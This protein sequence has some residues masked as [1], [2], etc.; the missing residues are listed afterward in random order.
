MKTTITTFTQGTTTQTM[1]RAKNISTQL[2]ALLTHVSAATG[3]INWVTNTTWTTGTPQDLTVAGYEIFAL[4]DSLQ[5]TAPLFFKFEYGTGQSGGGAYSKYGVSIWVTVGRGQDGAGNI[6][7]IIIPRRLIFSQRSVSG[8]EAS[9]TTQGQI[10]MSNM[11]GSAITFCAFPNG[12][13]NNSG[14]YSGGYFA[15]E[16]SRDTGGNATDA[17][18]FLQSCFLT[19]DNSIGSVETLAV[20][21]ANG[22]LNTKPSGIAGIS[23]NLSN[24]VSIAMGSTVP[25]FSGVAIP[26][27]GSYWAPRSI[28]A[29]AN[30]NFGGGQVV[31][32][33]IESRDYLSCGLAG[34]YSDLG[35][36]RYAVAGIAWY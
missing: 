10:Y 14:H 8:Q 6:T 26:G 9:D 27:D 34:G 30:N 3:Q 31:A 25:I 15:I 21:Y 13:V 16:R 23:F 33:L 2:K 7:N 35:A 19:Y 17:G 28:V 4:A 1:Q 12:A 11:D 20:G 24:N 29:S 18:V 22:T 32:G 5:A 36:Q